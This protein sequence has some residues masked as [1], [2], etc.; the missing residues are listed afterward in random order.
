MQRKWGIKNQKSSSSSSPLS[1][2]SSDLSLRPSSPRFAIPHLPCQPSRP[3]AAALHLPHPSRGPS[4]PPFHCS[5]WAYGGAARSRSRCAPRGGLECG[6]R[7]GAASLPV[8]CAARA[9]GVRRG[10]AAPHPI[11]P[12]LPAALPLRAQCCSPSPHLVAPRL[13]RMQAFR[14]QMPPM[15]ER[16]R[17]PRER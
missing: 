8:A 17:N 16:E 13:P 11:A 3:S 15:E 2:I 9:R 14:E 12:P 6:A 7:G 10:A 4:P 1:P 5:V